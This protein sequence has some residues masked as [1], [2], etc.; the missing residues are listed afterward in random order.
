[1]A[2]SGN[3]NP[4][5]ESNPREDT[6]PEA[7]RGMDV[8]SRI[9]S[10]CLTPVLPIA[11]GLGV[12]AWMKWGPWASIAGGILAVLIAWQLFRSLLASLNRNS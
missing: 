11:L 10:A 12:D 6:R 8:A 7:V 5:E 3:F 1:V 9:I 2:K 4:G